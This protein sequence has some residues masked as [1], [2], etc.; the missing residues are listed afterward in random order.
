[1]DISIRS[2]IYHI[3]TTLQVHYVQRY[4]I[5]VILLIILNIILKK[6]I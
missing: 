3:F 1:M 4:S 6:L 2:D 5:K